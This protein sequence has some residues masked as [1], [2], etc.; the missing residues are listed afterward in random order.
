MFDIYSE[1]WF[2][3]HSGERRYQIKSPILQYLET[4]DCLTQLHKV[5]MFKGTENLLFI[6]TE[7]AYTL[8]ACSNKYFHSGALPWLL[9]ARM[10]H[11]M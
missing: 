1:K 9:Y 5:G 11:H 3:S 2:I 6:L 7:E 10:L 4:L 8:I